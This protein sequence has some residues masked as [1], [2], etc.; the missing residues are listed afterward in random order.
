MSTEIQK[1]KYGRTFHLPWTAHKTTDDK[2]WDEDEL[3]KAFSGKEIIIT[4][5]MDGWI[6]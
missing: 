3:V 6:P 5:K 1:Y 4:E 2:I